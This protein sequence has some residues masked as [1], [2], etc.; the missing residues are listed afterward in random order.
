M[1]FCTKSELMQSVHM[2]KISG[3]KGPLL[4]MQ[5]IKKMPAKRMQ[6]HLQMQSKRS[7]KTSAKRVIHAH[8]TRVRHLHLHL[9]LLLHYVQEQETLL[10]IYRRAL[11]M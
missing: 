9:H 4:H 11:G 1:G 7:C 6:M 3:S 5:S 10:D 8:H 2:Q